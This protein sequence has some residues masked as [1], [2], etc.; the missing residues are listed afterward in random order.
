MWRWILPLALVAALV[1]CR[2]A[3]GPDPDMVA[4]D[5]EAL[6]V[7]AEAPRRGADYIQ[8]I[9]DD[10]APDGGFVAPEDANAP[11]GDDGPGPD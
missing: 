11:S 7:G 9:G 2:P 10:I 5:L 3:D 1:G 4:D 6:G 8:K